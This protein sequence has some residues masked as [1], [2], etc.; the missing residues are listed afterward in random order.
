MQVLTQSRMA[1]LALS[2]TFSL[3][4]GGLT[5]ASSSESMAYADKPLDRHLD[6]SKDAKQGEGELDTFIIRLY[7]PPA[8]RYRGGIPGLEA[9]SPSATGHARF[10]VDNPAVSIYQNY[11]RQR[12]DEILAGIT[13]HTGRNFNPERRWQ[14]ALNGFAIETDAA[15]ARK[16]QSMPEVRHV[17]REIV[18]EPMT[19]AGPTHI[20]AP[21][22]W[23]GNATGVESK[24]EDMVV[25]IVDSGI[26]DVHESFAE[27]A[28]DGYEHQNPLGSGEFIG[29]CDP[30]HEQ[31]DDSY[32]CNDKLIGAFGFGPATN[33]HDDNGHGSH[34]AGTAAGNQLTTS[35]GFD[36]SGVAPRANIIN[37]RICAP[38]CSGMPDV[39]EDILSRGDLVDAVNYSI[40]PQTGGG[41]PY[42]EASAEA[43][44]SLNEGGVLVAAAG[45]NSGPGAGSISNF[46]PW[47]LTVASSNHGG[48]IVNPVTVTG[49]GDVDEALENMGGVPSAE[50]DISAAIDGDLVDAGDVGD[51][52]A[53]DALDADSMDG[54][55]GVASRGDCPFTDKVSNLADAGAIAAVITNH[56]SGAPIVMG[57]DD[58]FAVP[59]VMISLEDGDALYDWIAA[60]DDASAEIGVD[61]FVASFDGDVMADSSSRGPGSGNYTEFHGPDV[62][63]PGDGI[64]AAWIGGEQEYDTIGGTS[65]ASPH[66]AGAILLMRDL[67]PDW[68]PQEIQS[69]LMMSGYPDPVLKEDGETPADPFDRGN[70]R[71][72]VGAAAQAGLVLDETRDRFEDANPSVGDL[73]LHELNIAFLSQ[74]GCIEE[75][76]WTRTFKAV[77]AGTYEFTVDGDVSGEVEP[78]SATLSTGDEVEVTVTVDGP[79][80]ESDWVF[81]Q[82]LI[83]ESSGEASDARL[84]I[85]VLTIEGPAEIDAVSSIDT[86]LTGPWG[87]TQ[88]LENADGV[89][90]GADD[91]VHEFD[92]DFNATGN[93]H[94]ADWLDGGQGGGLVYTAAFGSFWQLEVGGDNCLHEWTAADG[95]Q[96]ASICPDWEESVQAVA[97]DRRDSTLWAAGESGLLQQID[98]SG[99]I[100]AT[101]QLDD[102]VTGL[103][104]AE[105]SGILYVMQDAAEEGQLLALDTNSGFSLINQY[106]LSAEDGSA[107]F[108]E[109]DRGDLTISC[110]GLVWATDPGTGYVHA[111]DLPAEG[112]CPSDSLLLDGDV[113]GESRDDAAVLT[114]LAPGGEV[115]ELMWELNYATE[116]SAWLEEFRM[117]IESP[118]GTVIMAGG[119]VGSFTDPY[120]DLD[121]DF[122][123]PGETGDDSDSRSVNDFN[124]EDAAG[125]WTVR[126]WGTFGATAGNLTNDSRIQLELAGMSVSFSP[127]GG[128][129]LLDDAPLEVS[130][131]SSEGDNDTIRYTLDGSE[132][133][134]DSDSV[135]SGGSVHVG[136]ADPDSGDTVELRAYAETA[137]GHTDVFNR[138]YTFYDEVSVED[139]D[140][141]P[142]SDPRVSAGQGVT[143]TPSS[144]SGDYSVDAGMNTV[145]GSEVEGELSED[146]GEWTFTA[147]SS[148]A[149]AGSYEVTVTDDETGS[150]SSFTVDVDLLVDADFNLLLQGDEPQS[151]AVRGAT[152]GYVLQLAVQDDAGDDSDVAIL[153]PVEVEAVDDADSGNE[154]LTMAS[155]NTTDEVE[156]QVQ[157]QDSG[158]TYDTVTEDGFSIA[159]SRQYAGW[160]RS[161]FDEP[162]AGARVKT[163]EEV[164]PDG[165]EDRYRAYTDEEGVFHLFTPVPEN[166]E[167]ELTVVADGFAM[168]NVG[169]ADCVGSEPQ[170]DLTVEAA[171][172]I[173]G[174]MAGLLAD[175]EVALTL[176]DSGDGSSI[177]PM[178]LTGDGSGEDA[179]VLP[180]VTSRAYSAI[181]VTG[182]GYEPLSEDNDGMGYAFEGDSEEIS[183][184]MLEPTPTTPEIQAVSV[185][186]G[187]DSATVTVELDANER[188][189]TVTVSY[190]SVGSL[191]SESD[192]VE[193]APDDDAVE[194]TIAGLDCGS[195]FEMQA[196]A[197]NDRDME[198]ESDVVSADTDACPSASSS[199]SSSST[200]SIG[201]GKGRLDPS[202]PL[203]ILL[204]MVGLMAARRRV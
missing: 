56:E 57:G 153:D 107:A 65:M 121:Y 134:G 135:T 141:D 166:G 93:S 204:S 191:D 104:L 26:N 143:F 71:V 162:L 59:A 132:P 89:W 42:G 175:E 200:C 106:V 137:D 61:T 101:E 41:D 9:T 6:I 118:E 168:L 105:G 94:D 164:G 176:V 202:L 170:C 128:G 25:A 113:P 85:S 1:A 28:E 108:G 115:E 45:G 194:V 16:I 97:Y 29:A 86:E 150:S 169:G 11:L 21:E 163:T 103:A 75:C 43:F 37:Y 193:F 68:T 100:L 161:E 30:D 178:M 2:L 129:Y 174:Q 35:D 149:F 159:E 15:T 38:G 188:A 144:G 157:V 116:G 17:K 145:S 74:E 203:L 19:F 53:C 177:G 31:Y 52:L 112:V 73:A 187:D 125:Q 14:L 58:P 198:D 60:N 51:P 117:E 39:A 123:W 44:L 156:F 90:I 133:D 130:L 46:G 136:A 8:V 36:I 67:Y 62:V 146:D 83:S 181:E 189:G 185:T 180:A 54:A 79:R 55:I 70:G 102:S 179:F 184:V 186:A 27:V 77:Q 80:G 32:Q 33:A 195:S 91:Q 40:G 197:V 127:D 110:D 196:V 95:D 122:G 24:G 12:Q 190:G 111:F 23:E 147:P 183:G 82:L 199:S 131:T 155:A 64:F 3:A 72:D 78:A 167:H 165:A 84:P 120:D 66:V 99:D 173:S 182:T 172:E 138:S 50:F 4:A 119:G 98:S 48:A 192:A 76:T 151:L 87:I 160:V 96:G 22:I 49:P 158:G 109:G 201:A 63:A 142:I 81:G 10:D 7:E 34:V 148:G 13:Q 92:L 69:A 154:A 88:A 18:Y 126:V 20:A 5:A 139:G 124:G 152:P 140:G 171:G 47:N 114:F